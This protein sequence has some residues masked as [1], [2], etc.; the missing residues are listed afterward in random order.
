MFM[1]KKRIVSPETRIKMRLAQKKRMDEGRHNFYKGHILFGGGIVNNTKGLLPNRI[2]IPHTEESKQKIRDF[3]LN[4]SVDERN[5]RSAIIRKS[6][7]GKKQS[8]ETITKRV[9]SR[10]GY[11]HSEETRKKISQSQMGE[12]SHL[13]VGGKTNINKQIRK[14]VDFK[15]WRESVF[16]RDNYTCK[17]CGTRGCELHPHHIKSFCDYPELRFEIDNGMTLCRECHL[18]TDSWGHKPLK[19]L[20]CK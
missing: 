16:R 15:L 8:P 7:L 20:E 5:I 19:I 17:L 2:G 18:K 14:S 1:I 13:W 6:L 12:K 11:R 9:A 3:N 4:M 10:K